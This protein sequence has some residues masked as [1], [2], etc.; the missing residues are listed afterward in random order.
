MTGRIASFRPNAIVLDDGREMSADYVV[1]ATGYNA[2]SVDVDIVG[3]DDRTKNYKSKADWAQYH[4]VSL[5]F[6]YSNADCS[7]I[8]RRHAQLLYNSRKQHGSQ[9]Q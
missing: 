1:L 8:S 5:F 3:T 9:P 6:G 7:D 4:G 2:E